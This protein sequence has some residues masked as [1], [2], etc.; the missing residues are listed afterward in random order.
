M[1]QNNLS[2]WASRLEARQT[3]ESELDLAASLQANRPHTPLPRPE[4][5]NRL[6]ARLA[7]RAASQSHQTKMSFGWLGAAA[8]LALVALVTIFAIRL[9]PHPPAL[10]NPTQPAA[11]QPA[12]PTTTQ[13]LPTPVPPLVEA[14]APARLA[15][16]CALGAICAANPDGSA[17]TTLLTLPDQEITLLSV[18]PDR[19]YLLLA[20]EPDVAHRPTPDDQPDI[21]GVGRIGGLYT[22][23]LADGS[24]VQ[25]ADRF[26]GG[27]LS[28]WSTAAWQ[29]D[30]QVIFINEDEN[31]QT[32]LYRIQPNGSG[33]TRL[34]ET[35]PS[36]THYQLLQPAGPERVYWRE[37]ITEDY[38][39][40]MGHYWW[41]PVSGEQTRT[42]A[43]P[44][45]GS[46]LGE[47]RI[48]PAGG[49]IAYSLYEDPLAIYVAR[50]DASEP[51]QVWA[52]PSGGV[53]AG[54]PPQF[55]WAPDGRSLLL[56][57]YLMNS[58]LQPASV[59]YALYNLESGQIIGLPSELTVEQDVT[60]YGS[61]V[62]GLDPQWSPDGKTILLNHP[63]Y[64]YPMLLDLET[65][66]V[67]Q[68]LTNAVQPGSLVWQPVIWLP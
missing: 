64:A 8:G 35:A 33:L 40:S 43:W 27:G 50:L 65:M 28:T 14:P 60:G 16:N 67:S 37:G 24:L 47:V 52:A 25:L 48:S 12:S 18:S 20:V 19:R 38:A 22:L 7:Q 29:P 59:A 34:S 55:Y 51:R 61:W 39:V 17:A 66:T 49:Q 2:E 41:S 9:L 68:A 11:I 53:T 30:G 46:R 15:Y 3:G 42:L 13:P 63:H 56:E 6:Q 32:A 57:L 44:T 4:F 26:Q 45:L 5:T 23:N 62:I 36:P 10:N 21:P 1:S 58:E 54:M 31:L